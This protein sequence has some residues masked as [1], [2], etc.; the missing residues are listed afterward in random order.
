MK[1][2]GAAGASVVRLP[3]HLVT[4][5]GAETTTFGHIPWAF[6]HVEYFVGAFAGVMANR[7]LVG[8]GGGGVEGCGGGESGHCLYR[9]YHQWKSGC[10]C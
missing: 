1:C 9:G 4:V 2:A 6:H 7:E 10:C 8:G 5:T 3:R